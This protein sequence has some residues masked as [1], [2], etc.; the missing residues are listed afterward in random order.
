MKR[1][2]FSLNSATFTLSFRVTLTLS[3]IK[4]LFEGLFLQACQNSAYFTRKQ[5]G[6]V[7]RQGFTLGNSF[8]IELLK[9]KQVL[10]LSNH[11][12]SHEASC[13]SLPMSHEKTY[14]LAKARPS[15]PQSG[16][17]DHLYWSA[18]SSQH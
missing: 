7:G 10:K 2:F 15:L 14:N 5:T 18:L 17:A 6:L 4:S 12:V 11:K 8:Q 9:E 3:F 1:A 13:T 16:A